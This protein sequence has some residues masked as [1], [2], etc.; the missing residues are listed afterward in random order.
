MY[1]RKGLDSLLKD[2]RNPVNRMYLHEIML[3][4]KNFE[5]KAESEKKVSNEVL[6][7]ALN[8]FIHSISNKKYK[9]N[10][11][12]KNGFK[13]DSPIFSARYLD[14]LL[15]VLIKRTKIF[16]NVGISWG[17]QSF[18]SNLKFNPSNLCSMSDHP[19]FEF[20]SSPEILHLGQK[21]DFQFRVT[22]KRRFNKY[23]L[24]FP[25]ILFFTYKNLTEKDYITIEYYTKLA[26]STFEKSKAVI[27]TETLED[28]FKPDINSSFFDAIFVLRK[29]YR[30]DKIRDIQLDVINKLEKKIRFYC[31]ETQ[32]NG[33]SLHKN[34]IIE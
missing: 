15:T 21:F 33:Y 4:W 11:A 24:D 14:D 23:Q 22:G 31:T 5:T 12:T 34:G 8:K 27:V 7:R 20:S 9:Y 26:K 30:S 3:K 16:E 17:Y 6:L 28:N 25:L 13:P 1:Y 29:Q 32:T 2:R 10:N 19:M 18:S